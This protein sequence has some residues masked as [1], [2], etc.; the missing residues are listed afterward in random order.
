MSFDDV[1]DQAVPLRLLRNSI[2]AGRI[3]NGLL[4]WG[5]AGVGKR[6][7][8]FELVKALNCTE[9][10]ADCCGECLSCRK[11]LHG[12]HAD[13]KTI[14]PT[15][16][17]RAIGVDAVDFMNDLSSYAPFEGG[18]RVFLIEDADRMRLPA[19]N[20]FLKTLEEPPSKTVFVLI[21]EA[22]RRLLPTIRSRCQP[23][24]FGAL[25]PETVKS[26]LLRDRELP[27]DVA[28]AIAAVSQ[29]QMSLAFS[30]VD[31]DKRQVV[32]DVA[33]RLAKGEDPYLLSEEFVSHLKASMEN[34]RNA[35]GM[36]DEDGAMDDASRED[37]EERKREQEALIES[38]I[39]RD[40]MEYL[41]LLSTWY[42][43]ELVYGAS[44]SVERVLNRDQVD[45]LDGGNS[46]H[47]KVGAIEKAWVYIERNLNM[48]RVFRDL[49]FALAA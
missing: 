48:D 18:W 5:P 11:V 4:F 36:N 6:F 20:H 32:L 27:E 17:T 49:F 38:Y 13:V 46:A 39:R 7:A 1:K 14:T 47:E 2:T 8:A 42:R 30:L 40:I 33:H 25:Q 43:D 19:Q 34:V 21:T 28:E 26:L 44:Q 16:K 23:V 12:N 10:T 31:S 37:R 45:R 3:P 22:P 15:G 29:G 24:R 9:R 35:L 41:Y